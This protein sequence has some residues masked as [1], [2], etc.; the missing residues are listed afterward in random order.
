MGRLPSD[1][2]ARSNGA[3]TA[4]QTSQ[5]SQTSA[6]RTIAGI[7]VLTAVIAPVIAEPAL[8]RVVL[9]SI[10]AAGGLEVAK[11]PGT[12]AP[13]RQG[14]PV[15]EETA[16]RINA[17]RPATL[18][19]GAN[20]ILGLREESRFRVGKKGSDGLPVVLEG[21]SELSFR[22]PEGSSLNFLTDAAIVKGPVTSEATG[23]EMPIRGT[24]T[25]R[26][27]ETIVQIKEGSVRIRNRDADHFVS[28][29]SGQQASV[30]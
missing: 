1:G 2:V 19:L 6:A 13:G 28:V 15:L 25:Q 4:P 10:V 7:L 9:G 20:G 5:V 29:G 22:L 18:S 27:S 23:A 3:V 12:W 26:G 21:E 8:T 30:P 17:G 16:F 14:D 24:I 11:E